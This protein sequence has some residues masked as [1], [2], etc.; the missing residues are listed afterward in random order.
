MKIVILG[1]TGSGKSTIAKTI[2]T[3]LNLTVVEADDEVKRLNNGI[4]PKEE[5]IIDKYF[6]LT[7]KTILTKDNILYV[8]SWLEKERIEEFVNNGFKI[9]ELH[10][11]EEELLKRKVARD[12]V[13]KS[14]LGRFRINYKIYLDI[15][16]SANINNL[17]HISINTTKL[18]PEQVAAKVL[19][20]LRN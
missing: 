3:E 20:S 14:E 15:T 9:I 4:W 1:L 17:F 13:K 2:A 18:S 6:E 10:A 7:N 11:N 19:D 5:E 16:Q 8:T 12:K